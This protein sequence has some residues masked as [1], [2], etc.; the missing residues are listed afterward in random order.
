MT[1]R[2]PTTP[3]PLDATKVLTALTTSSS[4]SN[5]PPWTASFSGQRRSK[6]EG[7]KP[8]LRGGYGNTVHP[9]CVTASR[10]LTPV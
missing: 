5:F 9:S 8:A 4:D 3:C 10:V 1:D 2:Y 7:P 6:S